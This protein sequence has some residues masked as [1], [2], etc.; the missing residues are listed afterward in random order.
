MDPT[1]D[2]RWRGLGYQ[3]RLEPAVA[4]AQHEALRQ[5]LESAGCEV[6]LLPPSAGFSLDAIYTHDASFVS[7]L[8]AVLLP[9]GKAARRNETEAHRSFYR[10]LGIPIFAELLQPATAEAGDIVW[11]DAR[12]LLVGRGFRT[13]AAGIEQLRCAFAPQGVEV[14]AAPLPGRGGPSSCLHL[15]S[16]MSMLDD[17]TILVDPEWLAVETLELFEERGL[18]QIEIAPSERDTLACN[19]LALGD[20]K[21]LALDVN[22]ETNRRLRDHGFEVRTFPGSEIA[23]NGG[24]GP[25]CLTRPLLRG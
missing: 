14:I 5:Q 20:R 13:N 8:G 10:S 12:T 21:L 18:T 4:A 3:H 17:S 2:A 25:T 24:G 7:D 19:V 6:S 15:M 9:M 23:L 1:Q 11:L 22:S 16:L